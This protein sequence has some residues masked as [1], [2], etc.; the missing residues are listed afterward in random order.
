MSSSAIP[1]IVLAISALL[2][3]GTVLSL[4][5]RRLRLPL[6]FLL[7]VVGLLLALAADRVEALSSL[8]SLTLS[9]ELLVYLF[10][11][12]LLFDAA[13]TID[14]RALRQNIVP[15]LGLAIPAV[16]ITFLLAGLGIHYLLAVPAAAAFL[17]AALISAADST[18]ALDIFNETAAPKR[19]TIL[20]QG[21]NLFND[22]T[23][24][25]LF[26]IVVT[27]A[28]VEGNLFGAG[29]TTL[30][31]GTAHFFK[32]FFGGLATGWAIALLAGKIIELVEDDLIEILLTT[33]AVYL[34]FI[35]GETLIASSGIMSVVGTGLTLGGWGRTK[36]TPTSLDYLNRFWGYLAFVAHALIFLLVGLMLDV[37]SLPQ[38]LLPI[39]IAIPVSLVARAVSIYGL[40]PLLNR[41]PWVER[42]DFPHQ[43]AM[44]WGGLRG[45]M[46]LVLAL[47]I[48]ETYAYREIIL[49]MTVGVVL[50]SLLVQGLTLRPLVQ[51]LGLH[52][53]SIPERYLLEESL[54]TAKHRARAMMSDLL[55]GGVFS[56]RVV[57]SLESSYAKQEEVIQAQIRTV[58]EQG[59]IDSWDEFRLLKREHLLFEKRVYR[60]LFEGGQLSEKVY[61][62]LE[63][64][65][66][67]QLDHLR[68]AEGLPVW[69]MYSPW[70]WR[71][72]ANV[73]RVF[74]V[75][76]P[77]SSWVQRYRLRRIA[78]RY[79][80]QWGRLVASKRVLDEIPR[81]EKH[82]PKSPEA[83][84]ELRGL[85]SRW[86]E[87]ARSR[88]DAVAQQF[89]EYVQKVQ[90]LMVMR[91]CL[92]AE[93]KTIQELERLEV[94]PEREA[95]A[96]REQLRNQLRR[97]R[98][99]P[100]SELEP[101]ADELLAKVPF[102]KGLPREEFERIVP[103]LRQRTYLANEIIVRQGALDTSM[104]LISRGVVRV[105]VSRET[106]GEMPVATLLAGDFF[107]EMAALTA[108]P[109]T[110]TV[111]AVTDC[112]V[113]VMRAED[114]Q[115][116]AVLCPVLHEALETKY[117]QRRAEL[118]E[119]ARED[120]MNLQ[121]LAANTPPSNL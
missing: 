60:E 13:F 46:C 96:V 99:R 29:E 6:S 32:S 57:R 97:L 34:S 27:F 100:I 115:A 35:A 22:A 12:T 24:V 28:G 41:L 105:I 62:E 113:Y 10:L 44:A 7:V 45:A 25:V 16:A 75:I 39:A 114:L 59:S 8:R 9:P 1:Q 83:L 33:A 4:A 47:A 78:E 120:A 74:D 92:Q 117:F 108:N 49:N 14:T 63:Q 58:R 88:L 81:I 18:A 82:Y 76:A 107:G 109:R 38:Y 91:L 48:P 51:W 55:E 15:V 119:D 116:V 11:P 69:T 40:F 68:K 121:H 56:D 26:G 37:S 36:Y 17:F 54:L 64:S 66:G 103:L 110:A 95:R 21:E 43:T 86:H 61:K 73:F 72:E 102:F 70:G 31:G 2:A 71:F 79:E 53:P 77:D 5:A 84:E 19:L 98:E 67:M 50:F 87:T 111:K 104:F 94:L 89:P 52:Q 65:I 3:L 112:S 93:E 42:A 23:A 85:Y 20:A 101:R 90:E 106:F 118:D 30:G 80:A